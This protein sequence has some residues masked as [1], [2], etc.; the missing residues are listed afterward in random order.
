MA[1]PRTLTLGILILFVGSSRLPAF[2]TEQE[3]PTPFEPTSQYE[4][5]KVEGWTVLVNKGFLARKPE[6]AQKTVDLLGHQLYQVVTRI[7]ATPLMKLRTVRIWLEEA[8]PH[9]PCMAYHPDAGWLSEHGMNPEKARCVEVANAQKFLSWTRQQPWM[10]LHELAHAYHHQF[11]V[12]GFENPEIRKAFED[13]SIAKLYDS[14]L[15]ISG[16]TERAYAATDPMEYF[17]ETSEA[18]FGT[19]DFYPFVSAELR[20]HDLSMYLLLRRLWE[21]PGT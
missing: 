20:K 8:E 5:R 2:V 10:V 18:F 11:L 3:K 16:K 12:G 4:V 15:R 7:P 13:S 1:S 17:A 19:N 9:H 6:L 21:E 14:V